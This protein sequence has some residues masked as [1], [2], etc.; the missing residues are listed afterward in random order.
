MYVTTTILALE[1][2]TFYIGFFSNHCGDCGW[3][4]TEV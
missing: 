2:S 4:K 3:K 1:A